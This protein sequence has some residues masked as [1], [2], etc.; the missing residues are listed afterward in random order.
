[1]T[2]TTSTKL[3]RYDGIWQAIYAELLSDPQKQVI[4]TAFDQSLAATR[5]TP[6][7]AWGERIEDRGSQ[8]TFSALCQQAPFDAKERWDPDFAKRRIIQADLRSRLPGR[9]INLGG[10]TSID[11]TREGVPKAYGL[12]NLRDASGIALDAML[13]IDDAIFPGGDDYPA[14]ERGLYA[15]RVRDPDETLSVIAAIVACQK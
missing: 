2:P 3:Y 12:K 13:F 7:Q 11:V 15:V 5:F 8:I 6:D 9:S 4:L 14:Q 1:M 10:A